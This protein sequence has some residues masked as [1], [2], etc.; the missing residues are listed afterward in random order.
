M[1]NIEYKTVT[2]KELK[3]LFESGEYDIEIDTP[4]GYRPI[5]EWFD[6]GELD[7]VRVWTEDFSTDC[8]VNHLIQLEN[9]DWVMA[10]NLKAGDSIIT[11]KGIQKVLSTIKLE[12]MECYDFT[13]D[14]P[15]HRYYG[16]GIV[17]HN[18]G[19]SYI[20]SGNIV[21]EAQKQGIFPY[22]I[23]SENA[24]DE[25]WLSDLG[26]DTSIEKMYK[27]NA[28]M[29]DDVAKIISDVVKDYRDSFGELPKEER[30][31]LLFIIDSIGML[32]T[33]VETSQFESGDMK[34]DMGRKAK[35]LKTL[36]TNCVNMFGD[37]N[38][39]LIGT[40]HTYASQDMFDPDPKVSGG[41]G[42]VYASSI[43][44]AMRKLKLKEDEDGNKT[45]HV[46]G[47]RAMCKVMK[48]RFNKPFEDV[49]IKI[50]Y[51]TGMNPYSGLLDMFE[52][53]GLLTK[54]G[55]R[56]LYVDIDSGEQILKYRKD[57]EKND[58][59]CLDLVMAQF[60]RHPLIA[61]NPVEKG[62]EDFGTDLDLDNVS[63]IPDDIPDDVTED[64]ED[65]E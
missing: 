5:T 24:L 23:D 29:I 42:F 14:H 2:V 64:S 60:P 56:L 3:V 48:T 11:K 12:P 21:R 61:S 34:G 44:V 25:K 27:V 57:W 65:S 59:S 54:S 30:P 28:A 37:L 33:P 13:V 32:M 7:M 50:P 51:N 26:V 62:D 63:D 6:K 43:L 41:S 58:K 18:S 15:N 46:N 49:E 55:N 10:E 31:K 36:V 47:I 16:D 9:L 22:I 17:S 4:D 39:G 19:K 35:Q 20:V 45:T 53:N 52:K 8:A 40:Q 1:S 38:I